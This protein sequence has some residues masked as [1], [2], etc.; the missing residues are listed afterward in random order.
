MTKSHSVMFIRKNRAIFFF[1]VDEAGRDRDTCT[2]FSGFFSK[3]GGLF[4]RGGKM[5]SHGDSTVK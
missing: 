2:K 3:G 5:V 4:L 1:A